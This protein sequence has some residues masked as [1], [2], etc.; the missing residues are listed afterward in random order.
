MSPKNDTIWLKRHQPS[1]G[2]A[3]PGDWPKIKPLKGPKLSPLQIVTVLESRHEVLSWRR[4]AHWI[5]RKWGRTDFDAVLAELNAPRLSPRLQELLDEYADGDEMPEDSADPEV[6]FNGLD[7]WFHPTSNYF[8]SVS[9]EEMVKLVKA[10]ERSGQPHPIALHPEC[11]RI[12]DGRHR[13]IACLLAGV[14]PQFRDWDGKGDVDDFAIDLN[15]SGRHLSTAQ[16][17]C[18]AV[19]MLPLYEEKA[20]LRQVAA[21][22]QNRLKRR[23]GKNSGTEKGDARDLVAEKFSISGRTV[24]DAKKIKEQAPDIFERLFRGERDNEGVPF[25]IARANEEL[26]RRGLQKRRNLNNVGIAEKEKAQKAGNVL[27]VWT[28]GVKFS[29]ITADPPWDYM[30]KGGGKGATDFQTMTTEEIMALRVSAIAADDCHLYLWVPN[31]LV[32][33]DGRAVLEAWGFRYVS[34]LTWVKPRGVP[35]SR[36]FNTTE[37]VLFGVRPSGHKFKDAGRSRTG[38]HFSFKPSTRTHSAKPEKF[39]TQIVERCSE[40]P[41]FEIFGRPTLNGTRK[42]WTFW[43]QDGTTWAESLGKSKKAAK[44][45]RKRA[46]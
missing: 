8:P 2:K 42:N 25:R 28:S 14:I 40:G 43:G 34:I 27:D 45:K 23:S 31:S 38:T 26:V 16:R 41:Y 7:H 39:Y 4:A 21:L 12:L 37:Q 32:L 46:A 29:T 11:G 33:T 36:F 35:S 44:G 10:I 3:W 13:F 30:A 24:Q 18:I 1:D 17:A 22:K 15:V 5:A 6:L 20:R 9:K 19:N